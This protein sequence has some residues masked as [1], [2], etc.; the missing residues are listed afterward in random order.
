MQLLGP[1]LASKYTGFQCYIVFVAELV[2]TLAA[3]LL[4]I[5]PLSSKGALLFACYILPSLGSGYAVLMS[6]TIA[7]TA[8][9]TKRSASSSGLFIGYCVGMDFC[10]FFFG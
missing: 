6:L 3:I 1:Y 7:N 8:G 10:I 2:T 5:L 9:Y 4:W